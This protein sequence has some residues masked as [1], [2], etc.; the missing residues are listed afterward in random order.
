[1]RR[2]PVQ[3]R[4]RQTVE[5]ILSAAEQLVVDVGFE[6]F[7]ASPELL[8]QAA[9]VSRGSLYAYFTSP[10]TVL[11][12]IALRVLQASRERVAAIAAAPPA[13]WEQAVDLVVDCFDEDYRRPLVREIWLNRPLSPRILHEDFATNSS[14]SA[15]FH[16]L[17]SHY[18][19][20]FAKLEKYHSAVAIETLDSLLRY[21]YRSTSAGDPCLRAEA[22]TAV[23]AYLTVHA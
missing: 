2:Q 11:D 13:T 22:R 8:L 20:R 10:H 9:G 1:M 23:L 4:S 5:A 7:V 21:A 16:A 15:E 18:A 14:I 12:E 6:T 19:P 17:L 3:R